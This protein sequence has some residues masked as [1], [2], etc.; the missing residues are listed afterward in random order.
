MRTIPA[1]AVRAVAF[2]AMLA[3]L[4][5]PAFAQAATEVGWAWGDWVA[6][7]LSSILLAVGTVAT[8]IVTKAIAL[9]PAA[10]QAYITA[11]HR[12]TAEQLLEKAIA[13]GI[14][15]AKD[16]VTGKKLTVDVGNEVVA[17]ALNYV[18]KHGPEWLINWLGGVD[19]IIQKIIARLDLEDGVSGTEITGAPATTEAST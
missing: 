15:A 13:Y 3:A 10:I 16:Y 12:K 9:L 2:V 11:Q 5:T 8:F 7:V 1:T 18:I 14:N 19:A 6:A 17:E 4:A